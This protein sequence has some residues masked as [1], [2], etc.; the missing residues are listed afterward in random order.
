MILRD[1]IN[2]LLCTPYR[3]GGSNPLV[4][5]DCSGL[6]VELLTA[7]GELKHGQDF[8]AASLFD[9]YKEN[10]P[11]VAAFGT[12]SFYGKDLKNITHVGFCLDEDTMVEAGG[13][14]SKTL[15]KEDA[16]KQ[17]AWVRIRP[18]KYRSDFLGLAQAL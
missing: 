6:V 14:G 4:G 7:A 3:W 18:I 1:Y 2:A 15:T 13:G 10:Q 12:L 16:E 8:S 5:L 11:T 9:K 17:G